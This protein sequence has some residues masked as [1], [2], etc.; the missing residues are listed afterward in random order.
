ML[1]WISAGKLPGTPGYPGY[2]A[3]EAS[4]IEPEQEQEQEPTKPFSNNIQAMVNAGEIWGGYRHR[5][6][7]WK[8]LTAEE[9]MQYCTHQSGYTQIAKMPDGSIAYYPQYCNICPKCLAANVRQLREKVEGKVNHIENKID[10][11]QWRK[12]TLAAGAEADSFKKRVN[13]NQDKRHMEYALPGSDDAY[14]IWTYVEDE[15]GKDLDEI[16]GP[17]SDPGE[18]DFEAVYN[19]NRQTGKKFS[20]GSGLSN[21]SDA[22]KDEDTIRILIPGIIVAAKDEDKATDIIDQTNYLELAETPEHAA[23]LYQF[24]IKYIEQ[25]LKAAGIEIKAIYANFYNIARQKLL[26]GW[27]GNVKYWMSVKASIKIGVEAFTDTVEY[28]IEPVRMIH[29][30]L[31]AA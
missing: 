4:S 7:V 3:P 29:E 25:H 30:E 20:F 23:L 24:Q 14:E 1:E 19:N 27:N 6:S 9:K 16:Y 5:Q 22:P 21:S 10:D 18:I 28:L 2:K 8:F 13:R 17:V 11:G 31:S 26:D 12:K 15:P